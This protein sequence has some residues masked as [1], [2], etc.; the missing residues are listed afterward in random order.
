MRDE[1]E[2][3]DMNRSLGSSILFSILLLAT[4]ILLAYI[5]VGID[6]AIQ[7]F[8]SRRSHIRARGDL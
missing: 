1:A 5:A 8:R 3:Y 4:W 7:K 2:I 6:N